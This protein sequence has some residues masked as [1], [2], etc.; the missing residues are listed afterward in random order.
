MLTFPVARE[1]AGQR[2]DVFIQSRIPRLSRTRATA[3]VRACAFRV[4]GSRRRPGERVRA[5]EVVML[6]RERFVEPDVPL[7]F[8]T[9]YEDDWVLAVDKPSG[10]PMHPTA[11]YHRHTLTYLLRAQYGDHPPHI[12][13]RLD[14]E[15]SGVVLCGKTLAA[16]RALKKAFERR[17]LS[18]TYFALVRGEV[19]DDEGVI[20]VPIAQVTEGLHVMMEP[21]PA[22]DGLAARTHY[23]VAERRQGCTLLSLAP[24]TGRQHQLRVHLA[25]LGHPILGDKLYGPLGSEPFMEFIETGMTDALRERAGH[26]RQA[27]HAHAVEIEH[28]SGSGSFAVQSP[29]PPDMCA[30]LASF[31][32]VPDR[33]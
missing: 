15:T 20:D 30:L 18:K 12:A 9:L 14:R 24:L 2:L 22:G 8:G 6:V 27:L 29:M 19:G 10:L 1:F 26:D 7:E 17:A 25:T 11:T 33:G 13:H 4:D 5:G 23:R 16:E 32:A 28:P 3:I 31:D 21:K